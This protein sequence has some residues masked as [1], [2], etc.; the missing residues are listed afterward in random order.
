MQPNVYMFPFYPSTPSAARPLAA[1]SIRSH[2]QRGRARLLPLSW[3]APMNYQQYLSF[4]SPYNGVTAG[5]GHALE[6]FP[7]SGISVAPAPSR[8]QLAVYKKLRRFIASFLDEKTLWPTGYTP[9]TPEAMDWVSGV[10][11]AMLS[12]KHAL[13][14]SQ[15]AAN[16]PLFDNRR[17]RLSTRAVISTLRP[18][19]MHIAR[20]W[21][22]GR[23]IDEG[24]CR[25][26]I[27]PSLGL[28]LGGRCFASLQELDT[29]LDAMLADI[30]VLAQ[31]VDIMVTH[32]G[33]ARTD[34]RKVSRA[35]AVNRYYHK[36]THG[37]IFESKDYPEPDI[38]WSHAVRSG[39]L[40]HSVEDV[41]SLMMH[42]WALHT[43][44]LPPIPCPRGSGG[45]AVRLAV[46]PFDRGEMDRSFGNDP[47]GDYN[48][49]YRHAQNDESAFVLLGSDSA[50]ADNWAKGGLPLLLSDHGSY[51]LMMDVASSS[52]MLAAELHEAMLR[53]GN[54]WQRIG[55]A[56]GVFTAGQHP[57]T[58]WPRMGKLMAHLQEKA[59]AAQ[60][61]LDGTI[62]TWAPPSSANPLARFA[63][64]I[65]EAPTQDEQALEEHGVVLDDKEWAD[66]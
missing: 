40:P 5:A 44:C 9:Q 48:A 22:A 37:T 50:L 24:W 58:E 63:H 56:V 20:S 53:L 26:L 2:H 32:V 4:M 18:D 13:F 36:R 51:Q 35:R 23:P 29:L 7:N 55:Q 43:P 19:F 11:L 12:H 8:V 45:D 1:T 54:R 60:R 57:T 33:A 42:W 52:S 38:G 3:D 49:E 41:T 16:Q 61:V 62:T 17:V 31:Q 47:K 28:P 15:Y 10:D 39:I 46:T 6:F 14:P 66:D 25:T 30:H 34:A 27:W 59:G 64:M 65:V 21:D